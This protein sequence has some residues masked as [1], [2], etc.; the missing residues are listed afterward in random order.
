MLNCCHAFRF[1]YFGISFAAVHER[2]FIT[3][4]VCSLCYMLAT[5]KLNGILNARQTLNTQQRQSI[6][7]KKILFAVSILSTVGLLFFFAKHR[8]YCHDLGMWEFKGRDDNVNNLKWN[9]IQFLFKIFHVFNCLYQSNRISFYSPYSLQLVCI[10]WVFDR[11]CQYAVSFHHHLGLSIAIHA[12]CAGTAWESNAVF[13]RQAEDKLRN[14]CSFSWIVLL[15]S[16]ETFIHMHMY[17]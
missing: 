16:R 11:H 6:K 3:F 7:W 10:L 15:I 12:N 4:M 1:I 13:K 17:L 2:I 9:R 5:I 14:S 8:F